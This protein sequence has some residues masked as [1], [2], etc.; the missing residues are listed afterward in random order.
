MVDLPNL[1][2]KTLE[3]DKLKGYFKRSIKAFKK[4]LDR[5]ELN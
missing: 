1:F 3:E 2:F 5:Q 4:S